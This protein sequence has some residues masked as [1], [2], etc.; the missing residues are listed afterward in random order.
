MAL[1]TWPV[2]TVAGFAMFFVGALTAD[3]G[4]LLKHGFD[5]HNL[6]GPIGSAFG[7]SALSGLLIGGGTWLVVY[8]ALVRQRNRRAGL[9][10]FFLLVGLAAVSHLAIMLVPV[11]GALGRDTRQEDLAALGIADSY[12]KLKAGAPAIDRQPLAHGDAG[13]VEAFVR[14]NLDQTLGLHR[15]YVGEVRAAGIEAI[16]SQASLAPDA[17]LSQT[18]GRLRDIADIVE[19]YRRLS[20][21]HADQIQVDAARLPVSEASRRSVMAGIAAARPHQD[22]DLKRSWD[23]EAAI[24][25]EYQAAEAVLHTSRGHWAFVQGKL[26]FERPADL[27]AFRGRLAN[28]RRIV[29][30]ERGLQARIA[31]EN[32][33]GG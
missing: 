17:S 5:A 11:Y 16:F 26:S 3:P 32:P 22:A 28:V 7:S 24:V 33:A 31:S 30:E 1:R 8:F 15:A 6:S 21:M 25:A 27:S 2:L 23:N 12:R 18:E 4:A 29:E 19:K 13:A 20:L 9:R 10:H 14:A